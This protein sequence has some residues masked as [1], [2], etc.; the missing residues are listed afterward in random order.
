MPEIVIYSKEKT[1]KRL[2]LDENGKVQQFLSGEWARRM[3][4]IVPYRTGTL[5]KTVIIDG[6]PTSNVK[7]NKITYAQ[8][9][10]KYVYHGISRSGKKMEYTKTFHPK[11]KPYW[12]KEMI[13]VDREKI[14]KAVQNYIR[15]GKANG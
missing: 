2:G 10:A 4:R 14:V 5:S 1:I 6:Q 3:E 7:G 8:K 12:D 13:A 9:Y 15:S 11:V